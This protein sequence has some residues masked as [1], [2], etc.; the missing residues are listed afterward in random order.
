MIAAALWTVHK[1]MLRMT[2]TPATAPVAVSEKVAAFAVPYL[3]TNQ[4][5][6]YLPDMTGFNLE[7]VGTV[8]NG[9]YSLCPLQASRD[10][11]VGEVLSA[12]VVNLLDGRMSRVE[13]CAAADKLGAADWP[14]AFA[15]QIAAAGK[16][17]TAGAWAAD[18]GFSSEEASLRLWSHA[19]YRAF[20]TAPFS[21]NLVQALACNDEFVL[22][23]GQALCVQVRDLK[24]QRVYEN[25]FFTP[26]ESQAGKKWSQA[27]CE[28]LNQESRLLRAGYLDSSKCRVTPAAKG[29][30]FWVAQCAQ[31]CVTLSEVH[32]WAAREVEGGSTLAPEQT[33]TTWVYD[34]LSDELL[35]EFSWQPEPTQCAAG[36]WLGAWAAALNGSPVAGWVRASSAEDMDTL[37]ADD[38]SLALWYRGD[39]LRIFSTL[40]DEGNWVAGPR[41]DV[42]GARLTDAALVTIRHPYSHTLVHH[43]VYKPLSGA[44]A[45]ADQ[46]AWRA[47]LADFITRQQWPEVKVPTQDEQAVHLQLPR[48]ADWQVDLQ[49]VGD[50][51]V[52][53]AYLLDTD[54]ELARPV[55]AKAAIRTNL[56]RGRT[57]VIVD[58]V[59]GDLEFRLSQQARDKGYRVLA[60][61]PIPN[62]S[63]M[64]IQRLENKVLPAEVT[65]RRISWRGT[66]RNS[67]YEITLDYP[68]TARD[69]EALVVGHLGVLSELQFWSIAK[70]V[71]FTPPAALPAYVATSALC[72]DYGNTMQSEV[73]DV[74]GQTETGVDARTGLFHAH[75]PVVTL[76]GLRGLGPVCDLT[77]HYSC[78][79][80]NEAGL[81]DGW[82]WRFASLETR[83][84][85]LTLGDGQQINF[86]DEEWTQLGKGTCL[87]K[88]A[89][90]VRSNKDF[91]E[92]IL[93]L[94]SGRQE[95]LRK[96]SAPGGDEVEA[97]EDFRQR[98]ITL[99]KA[100]KDK[101]KPEDHLLPHGEAKDTWGQWLLLCIWPF[102]YYQAGRM[103][104]A[105]A[106]RQWKEK[107]AELDERISYYQRPFVQ[108]LPAQITSPY[109]AVLDLTWQRKAGQFLLRQVNS[110]ATALFL[111]DYSAAQVDMQIWPTSNEENF[112]VK[113]ELRE[114]L[115]RSLAREQ[116]GVLQQQVTCGY[117][118]DPTLDRILCRLQE[119]DGSVESV[120]YEH[121]KMTFADGRPALPRAKSHALIPGDG[122]LNEFT[123]YRYSR[124]GYLNA[125]KDGVY[126]VRRASTAVG[127]EL[128]VYGHQGELLAIAGL[129]GSVSK[130]N[131]MFQSCD[132][133]SNAF[134]SDLSQETLLVMKGFF[135]RF[136]QWGDLKKSARDEQLLEYVK[137]KYKAPSECGTEAE[138]KA[139]TYRAR[140]LYAWLSQLKLNSRV[141]GSSFMR[142]MQNFESG[143]L[144]FVF[145]ALGKENEREGNRYRTCSALCEAISKFMHGNEP[146][147][148]HQKVIAWYNHDSIAGGNVERSTNEDQLVY[149]CYYPE[150]GGAMDVGTHERFPVLACP[151]LPE[152]T[153]AP[154]MAEYQC[155]QHGNPLGLT[156]YGYRSER[157]NARD[158]LEVSDVVTL[159]GVKGTLV[160]DTLN[161]NTLWS[162]A[163]AGSPVVVR[164]RKTQVSAVAAKSENSKVMTWSVSDEQVTTLGDQSMTL[165]SVQAF[166][167][168]PQAAGILVR[169]SAATEA[170]SA[171]VKRELRS[172]FSRRCL[173]RVEQGVETHWRHDAVGR[174]TEQ[175]R[176]RLGKGRT[177]LSSG[178]RPDECI[179]THY[180]VDGKVATSTRKNREQ[181]R[182]HLDGLQRTWRT[183]WR[184][185]ASDSYRPLAECNVQGLNPSSE[186]AG[187]CW[188]YLPGGQALVDSAQDQLLPGRRPW[189]K[190]V[191]SDAHADDAHAG[192]ARAS[193]VR[194]V[195]IHKIGLDE[196]DIDET[197]IE[198]VGAHQASINE[199]NVHEANVQRVENGLGEQLL[200]TR[201]LQTT[202][203][204]D[205]TFTRTQAQLDA[206]GN[207]LIT[208]LQGFD[209][210]GAL[211]SQTHTLGEQSTTNTWQRDALGRVI[212][213]TRPDGSLVERTYHG[214]SNHVTELKVAGKVLATQTVNSLSTLAT[215]TVGQRSYTFCDDGVTLPDGHQLASCRTD[216]KVSYGVD[217]D[218]LSSLSRRA[219]VTTLGSDGEAN[220]AS[221]F[222]TGAWQHQLTQVQLPGRQQVSEVTPRRNAQG[223]HW[224][225]LRGI[226]VAS[227]RADG[228]WQR[229]FVDAAG[230]TLR[231]CQDH[232]DLLYRYDERGQL[233]SRRVQA[234]KGEGQWQVV[235]EHNALGQETL[236]SFLRNGLAVFSQQMTWHGDGRLASKASYQQ[237]VLLRSE[238]F[239][240][241]VMGR[242]QRYV[243]DADAAENC[244]QDGT[245]RRVAEQVFS[246]D[247]FD[248]MLQCVT[249]Y[250][251]K[252]T[253]TRSFTYHGDDPTRLQTVTDGSSAAVTLGWNSNGQLVSDG[254][255]RKLAYNAGGQLIKVSDASDQLQTRYAYDGYQRLAAQFVAAQQST[256]ELR[257][258]GDQL[259]G[260]TWFDQDGT[261]QRRV[262]LSA[263]LAEYEEGQVRWLI[264]D[265]QAGVAG[266]FEGDTLTLQ[267]LLPFGEGA[268]MAGISSGYN[269]MRRDPATGGYAAGNGYRWY[270]PL[271]CRYGQYDWLSPFGEGGLNGYA[272]CPD[273]INL[274]DPSGA[275]MISRW[276]QNRALADLQ[277]TLRDTQPMPVGG[278]WRGLALSLVLA[279][280][281]IGA[282]MLTGGTAAMA[283]FATLTALSVASFGL[284]V[285][286]VLLEDSNPELAKKLAIASMVTGVLS[287]GNFAGLFKQG[288]KLLRGAASMAMRVI[289]RAQAGIHSGMRV[290]VSIKRYGFALA[291]STWATGRQAAKSAKQA[292]KT[293]ARAARA[294]VDDGLGA[295]VSSDFAVVEK[296][297]L[298]KMATGEKFHVLTGFQ[299]KLYATSTQVP[300][301]VKTGAEVVGALGD[302][303]DYQ[304]AVAEFA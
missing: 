66:I 221:S 238:R 278:R 199:S 26:T 105:D 22:A 58:R 99:L 96:P 261:V 93:D 159:D 82:A 111:A 271:L 202:A 160:E 260:E 52:I 191:D 46:A 95:I 220:D 168:D 17:M 115:L 34:A 72:E 92:F 189:S 205:G 298:V 144:N 134:F 207:P 121:E 296:D 258:D 228:H 242:L 209:E 133:K 273:P 137:G 98:V 138:V 131:F 173:E 282:S 206:L 214:F 190:E 77:L 154:L 107:T 210:H 174:V 197:D 55:A 62:E 35:A 292:S 226:T 193:N 257:Y 6:G 53:D 19:K 102:G 109:G 250:T 140:L 143:W 164:H 132:L 216:D 74:T 289:R 293:W 57:G 123:S 18:G 51:A 277:Q 196:A 303:H 81:G 83:D 30:A 151:E 237:Q 259:I 225:S 129:Q 68:E 20:S 161:A 117:V 147:L 183:E 148:S 10:L 120:A 294:T 155:D 244:P 222:M 179:T 272:H 114:H 266:K 65:D 163:D 208:T 181:T 254:Q 301:R 153:R 101:S 158:C 287:I 7:R 40:P 13:Y 9:W 203:N 32:W 279:V 302:L 283:V 106:L 87:K 213:E 41:L 29:N 142:S 118:E 219:A 241:D 162:L 198:E 263:G 204:P 3:I 267:A 110:G 94:P 80:G 270:D 255:Q 295:L 5:N 304:E 285:A 299:A 274:H 124:T 223:C 89:C 108:L 176:Y 128:M 33:I 47:G 31:L 167:D 43:G 97:N 268:V 60:C 127:E 264:A 59:V 54:K 135:Q 227:L 234:L 116:G 104:W 184:R 200:S 180:S 76:Q 300:S 42:P 36:H 85:R 192:D 252:Q 39:A 177:A 11:V 218:L 63:A 171:E 187:W 38:K 182:S 64:L 240:Y 45:P 37:A 156:L 79:R 103:D 149:R 141:R 280:I 215:R 165:T 178:Q 15:K 194:G 186:L 243:C 44:Q 119:L 78:L 139:E 170:G 288:A 24:S 91:S 269:G 239:I 229:S 224:Q 126:E 16:P 1:R 185:D 14:K 27:L 236:R 69:G 201:T 232:E 50:G 281:G 145:M 71:S 291:R 246:W 70:E 67:I 166:E 265:P 256:C 130:T 251:D 175:Q 253:A 286:S 56:S 88:Q 169:S 211:V 84:R 297:L 275:I 122:Q 75:Y 12:C 146:Q 284:E 113:L 25:H 212:K 188:D 262:S 28:Q 152:G 23:K 2:T 73:F 21:G 248:N 100:I 231:T 157:R 90:H 195:A 8:D 61:A 48:G 172:R 4:A 49:G 86:T 112:T 290:F 217:N 150:K 136:D 249:T 230:R 276:G 247:A 245:G 233:Q 235:S 125:E